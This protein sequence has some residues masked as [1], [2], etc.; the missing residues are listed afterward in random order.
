M[1][2]SIKR[3]AHCTA[4][5]SFFLLFNRVFISGNS[6]LNDGTWCISLVFNGSLIKRVLAC[7]ILIFCELKLES[8]IVFTS[9]NGWSLDELSIPSFF[10]PSGTTIPECLKLDKEQDVIISF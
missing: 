10:S 4:S 5:N 1:K 9:G 2:V 3:Y 6:C 8:I 7:K